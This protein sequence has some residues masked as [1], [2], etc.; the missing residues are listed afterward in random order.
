M[1]GAA[2]RKVLTSGRLTGGV[3]GQQTRRRVTPNV[4]AYS[5]P[6]YSPYS[7]ESEDQVTTLHK[8]LDRCSALLNG[9][10]QAEKAVDVCVEGKPSFPRAAKG[11]GAKPKSSLALGKKTV[12]R[13]PAG[14]P[15][16]QR[17]SQSAR[18]YPGL[19]PIHQ[20]SPS[21]RDS[22]S[23][24]NVHHEGHATAPKRLQPAVAATHHTTPQP[25]YPSSAVSLSQP[26]TSLLLSMSQ[27]HSQ[28]Q[29]SSHTD[30]P[31]SPLAPHQPGYKAPRP[32]PLPG[33]NQGREDDECVPVRDT[34]T[35]LYTQKQS[36]ATMAPHAKPQPEDAQV[37]DVLQGAQ[38]DL[39]ACSGACTA[40]TE[41]KLKTPQHLFGELKALIA[42]Q[43]SVAERLLCDLEHAVSSSPLSVARSDLL[44][45][46]EPL[47]SSLLS[48]NTQLRRRVGILNQQLK[49]RER[50]QRLETHCS[51]EV[52]LLQAELTGLQ[53]EM[54]ELRKALQD[55]QTQL[56]VAQTENMLIVTDL[57]VTR[58]RLL[59]SEREKSE[60][61]LLA[62]QRL[63]EVQRLNRILQC[64]N[65]SQGPTEVI[66]LESE[67]LLTQQRFDQYQHGQDPS[68][69]SVE[70]ISQYL[71]SLGQPEPTELVET[72]EL[73]GNE[74][75]AAERDTA[76]A[77]RLPARR[78]DF[79]PS[80]CDDEPVSCDWS[81]GSETTFN[82]RDEMAFRD[83]LAA[84]DASIESLQKTIKMDLGR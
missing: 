32:T 11:G 50:Q 34:N 55:T 31:P 43:G 64:K 83:G 16:S 66:S 1:K 28:H 54:A 2:K 39:G 36:R 62:Q 77:A 30:L 29:A 51:S 18:S 69:S 38:S 63:E 76:G 37:D 61:A 74:R 67:R 24:A 75:V 79:S 27:S 3:K 33:G 25:E 72:R 46:T 58:S 42:G 71:L 82:T 73:Q 57:K 14:P 22:P 15:P 6:T 78:L 59:D 9:M 8:G 19:K 20:S 4:A 44:A 84:L 70:R 60:L 45:E 81:I 40:E 17:S 21:K 56:G 65:Q 13:P 35:E 26:Q 80:N 47:L 10:L 12:K 48:Q 68:E 49:E 7:A 52:L 41:G 23:P 5:Q 53:D